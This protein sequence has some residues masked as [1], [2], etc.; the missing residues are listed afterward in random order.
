MV[1]R[2]LQDFGLFQLGRALLLVRAGDEPF[3]LGEGRVDPVAALL[4]D[5]SAPSLPTLQLTAVRAAR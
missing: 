4:L 2:E 3:E 1:H 5:D